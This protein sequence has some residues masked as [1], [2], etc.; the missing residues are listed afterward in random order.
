MNRKHCCNRIRAFQ[1]CPWK[2]VEA[3]DAGPRLCGWGEDAGQMWALLVL[4]GMSKM[5]LQPILEMLALNST[6]INKIKVLL[7]FV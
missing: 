4:Q 5:K 7:L 1:P 2:E 6:A 3:T